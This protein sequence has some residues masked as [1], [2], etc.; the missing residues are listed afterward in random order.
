MF[1]VPLMPNVR[2]CLHLTLTSLARGRL[3]QNDPRNDISRV[4]LKRKFSLQY[5]KYISTDNFPRFKQDRRGQMGLL[6][7]RLPHAGTPSQFPMREKQY[8]CQ[9]SET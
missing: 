2:L 7:K 9:I 8:N 6:L 3:N 5:I 1:F 4:S